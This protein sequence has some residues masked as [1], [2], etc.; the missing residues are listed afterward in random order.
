M[1]RELKLAYKIIKWHDKT[2]PD[3]DS[4]AQ[5]SKLAEEI[6]EYNNAMKNFTKSPYPR[7]K[8]YIDAVNEEMVD[9]IIAAINCLKYPDF[10]ER[11]AV[12]HAKNT[13]RKW[14]GTHHKGE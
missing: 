12:K 4:L 10:F 9:I 2:F 14:I 8:N 6:R 7:R 1:F 11:V 5:R 13:H 3:A